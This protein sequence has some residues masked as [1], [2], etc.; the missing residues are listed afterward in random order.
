MEASLKLSTSVEAGGKYKI[1]SATVKNSV[2]AEL[3]TTYERTIDK[4]T[5]ITETTE[6]TKQF[7]VGGNS[8]GKMYRLI[9][10][11]PGVTYATGTVSTDENL[12]LEKVTINF[13]V[14]RVPMIKDIRVVY[15]DQSI[16][17]PDNIITETSG[18]D[19]DVN[20]G[21]Q[22]HTWLVPVW[23]GKVVS[24]FSFVKF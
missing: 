1:I 2:D 6:L 5:D 3:S 16:D 15:T 24:D 4:K 21:Y 13:K 14:Q 10:K 11:G 7:E 23:T 20:K 18:G 8:F 12:P 17:R 22:K 19:L 9:Y